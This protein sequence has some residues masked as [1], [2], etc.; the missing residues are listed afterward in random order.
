MMAFPDLPLPIIRAIP[1]KS[2]ED[3]GL[4]TRRDDKSA[5]SVENLLRFH[6]F[7][8]FSH[9]AMKDV[10]NTMS[11]ISLN[12]KDLLFSQDSIGD[13]CYV[14]V[15]GAMQIVVANTDES[16]VTTN[17]K[18]ALIAPG[19]PLGHLSFFDDSNR[20][21]AAIAAEDTKL[22]EMKKSTF[23]QLISDGSE[24]G[25]LFLYA[26]LDDLVDSMKNTNKRFQFA[27]SQPKST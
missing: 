12:K 4:D 15:S 24:I 3:I 8:G 25:F 20:S 18:V 14:V 11:L 16:D 22:L 1:E 21:A 27:I 7:T 10:L 17:S 6:L 13:R 2:V 19:R 5:V 23:D 9:E 26:L